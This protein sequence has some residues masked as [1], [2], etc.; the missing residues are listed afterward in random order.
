MYTY[1]S[2]PDTHGEK[3]I[4]AILNRIYGYF[5]IEVKCL[6]GLSCENLK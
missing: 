1:L 3:L 2:Y 6:M 4:L 5:K